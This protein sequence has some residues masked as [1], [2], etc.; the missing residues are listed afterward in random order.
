MS[1]NLTPDELVTALSKNNFIAPAGNI[2]IGNQ[3]LITPQNTTIDKINELENIPLLLKSGPTIYLKDV[4]NIEDGADFTTGYAL[5]NNKRSIYIQVT[6]RSDASTWEVVK[7][8]KKA[9][10]DMQ[11]AIPDD[12][13][14]SYEFDQSG[15]VKNSLKSLLFEGGLGAILTGLMVLLFLGDKRSALIVVVT[16]PIAL[17]AAVVGL[18]LTGQS[19]NIMTLGGLALA[20]GILVDEATVT[21]ENIHRHQEMGKSKSRAIADASRE[22]ALPKLLILFSILAV[23]VPALF[24]SGIPRAMFFPLSLAVGFA[25][26]AS[27]LLSQT[28][29]PV[30]SN[31]VL[32][33]NV[34]H[35]NPRFGKFRHNYSKRIGKLSK[36]TNRIIPLYVVSASAIAF[37]CF[38][39]TG[40]EIFPKVDAGQMQV[41]LRL[42]TGTR[43]ERTEDQTKHFLSIIDSLAGKENVAITSAFV[44]T[45]PSSFPNNTIYLWTSGPHEAVVK[46]NLQKNAGIHLSKLKEEIRKA[47]KKD[48][49]DMQISFEPADLVD[50]VMSLGT[51]TPIEI[52]V[53][54]KSLAQGKEYADKI[55][56]ELNKITYLRDVQYGLP[57]DYPTLELKYDRLLA[58]QFGLSISDASKSITAA[59]SSSRFTFPNFWID[60]NSGTAYQIQVELPQYLM[61]D[62]QQIEQIPVGSNSTS[63]VYFRDIASWKK[64]TTVGEY[65]RI[66]QQ[67]FI[68]VTANIQNKD[69]GTAITDVQKAITNIGEV[70]KGMKI[71]LRGQAELL[72]QTFSELGTGLLLAVIV[73]FLLLSANFQSFKQSLIILSTVPAIIAGA[74]LLLFL[75]GKTLNIQSFMGCIMAIGVSVANAILLVTN[76]ETLRKQHN[77]NTAGPEAGANRLRPILMTSL[78]MIAGMIPISIGFGEGGDQT[79]PLG[80]AV[81]GGLLFSTISTLLFLPLIYKSFN[82]SQSYINASL[83]PDDAESKNYGQ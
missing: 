64:S 3:T 60:K 35:P 30:L 66:N 31:W 70:P 11:A 28:F 62:P 52:A 24:M 79:A 73:I 23:F 81:I 20:V 68:T 47:V 33:N 75:T 17:L 77:L 74:F 12:I 10:P 18:F 5:V 26:I 16:I 69:L 71:N 56:A 67:R 32:K 43:V 34:A 21:I 37:V 63:K 38:H 65:D 59:T 29:V 1:Y 80:I 46:V 39:F 6:K 40:K 55:K 49:P 82:K 53:Q 57:L 36:H 2:R 76:A 58:G 44:G 41:R 14:I 13:K 19:I 25:M 48:I 22:I 45:Q 9:L 72:N 7:N 15:Y 54:G 50:Q 42:P 51:N 27:F 78:A 8:I 4:A 61:N 83:D